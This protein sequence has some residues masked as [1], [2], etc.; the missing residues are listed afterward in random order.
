[1]QLATSEALQ[2]L[3]NEIQKNEERKKEQEKLKLD[4]LTF[5]LHKELESVGVKNSIEIGKEIKHILE[6]YA[7]WYISE[8]AMREARYKVTIQIYKSI[9]DPDRVTAL[10]EHIFSILSKSRRIQ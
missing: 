3:L 4:S 8:K 6:E 2:K 1:R 7:D 5:Y 9:D 10:V